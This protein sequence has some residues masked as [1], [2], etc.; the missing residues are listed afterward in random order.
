MAASALAAVSGCQPAKVWWPQLNVATLFYLSVL[1]ENFRA[2]EATS[3]YIA[4]G[5]YS[6]SIPQL[7]D[8]FS[9]ETTRYRNN[10]L[11]EIT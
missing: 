4:P 9:V 8:K 5:R 6:L 2:V 10:C 7:S 3:S 11:N 1:T